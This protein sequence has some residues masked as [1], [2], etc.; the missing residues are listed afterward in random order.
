[1]LFLCDILVHE[2]NE[3]FIWSWL[4]KKSERFDSDPDTRIRWRSFLLANLVQAK[5]SFADPANGAIRVIRK[6]SSPKQ[7]SKFDLLK[8][9]SLRPAVT[10]LQRRLVKPSF[11]ETDPNLWD[12]TPIPTTEAA[13]RAKLQLCDAIQTVPSQDPKCRSPPASMFVTAQGFFPVSRPRKGSKGSR[14]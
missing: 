5:L 8:R 6:V 10:M 1:M 2:D 9:M 13:P 11:R 14:P 7:G 4:E 12:R 3:E